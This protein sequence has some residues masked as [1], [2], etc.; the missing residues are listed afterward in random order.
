MRGL[1]RAS[2]SG[3]L[4]L[5]LNRWAVREESFMVERT[6]RAKPSRWEIMCVFGEHHGGWFSNPPSEYKRERSLFS[7][8]WSS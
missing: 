8:C 6:A 7:Y 3:Y 4:V 2:S 1:V 5:C